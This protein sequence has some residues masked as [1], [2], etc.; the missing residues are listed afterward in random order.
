MPVILRFAIASAAGFGAGLVAA[1]A[2]ALL[3]L[4]LTGHGYGSISVETITSDAWGIHMSI[5]DAI[6]LL[7]AFASGTVAWTLLRDGPLT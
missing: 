6:L 3:D 1:I 4:Y 5:G 2:L 7:V